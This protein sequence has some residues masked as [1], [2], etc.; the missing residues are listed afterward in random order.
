MVQMVLIGNQ[1][2]KCDRAGRSSER[3]EQLIA[4][5]TRAVYGLVVNLLAIDL[6]ERMVH[7]SI[8]KE[9]KISYN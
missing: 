1:N 4:R 9:I 3:I 6:S 8:Q 7:G 2:E 5:N